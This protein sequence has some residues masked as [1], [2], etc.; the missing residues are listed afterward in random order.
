MVLGTDDQH[1]V[2][3]GWRCHA[4]FAHHVSGQQ[5]KLRAGLDHVNIP[6]LTR[7]KQFAISR[8]CRRSKPGVAV[9]KPLVIDGLS[10]PGFVTI[11]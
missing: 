5:F 3:D 8:D 1:S 11:Q 6:R 7:E 2:R 4:R 9:P 10:S